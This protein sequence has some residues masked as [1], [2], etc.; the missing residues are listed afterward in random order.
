MNLTIV[1]IYLRP[2]KP[3]DPMFAHQKLPF[4]KSHTSRSVRSAKVNHLP[5]RRPGVITFPTLW[6]WSPTWCRYDFRL[7]REPVCLN[8]FRQMFFD[9]LHV[10]ESFASPEFLLEFAIEPFDLALETLFIRRRKNRNHFQRQA[11]SYHFSNRVL[12]SRPLE[13]HVVVE[14]YILRQSKLLPMPDQRKYR[15]FRSHRAHRHRMQQATM[16]RNSIEVLHLLTAVQVQ[17]FDDVEAVELMFSLLQA[18]QIPTGWRRGSSHT[19]SLVEHPI[20]LEDVANGSTCRHIVIAAPEHFVANRIGTMKPKYAF[21]LEVFA[22]LEDTFFEL[23]GGLVFGFLRAGFFVVKVNAI[24]PLA[25]GERDPS[26]NGGFGLA[27]DFR[28][29]T[30]RTSRPMSGDHLPTFVRNVA[31]RFCLSC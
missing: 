17:S 28:D 12:F 19:S 29:L 15:V 13:N 30:E 21:F 11:K 1:Q 3:V 23:G 18:G 20:S 8:I 22:E 27:K 9:V 4:Q 7:M 14:L 26:L 2:D 10:F 16:Q 25:L 6:K 31:A 5:T 24:K